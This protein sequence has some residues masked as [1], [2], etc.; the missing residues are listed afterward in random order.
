MCVKVFVSGA[1]SPA[2]HWHTAYPQ[3]KQASF[4][5]G[6]MILFDDEKLCS[7]TCE[8]CVLLDRWLPAAIVR[9]VEGLRGSRTAPGTHRWKPA[10]P[11][12]MQ[13][14]PLQIFSCLPPRSWPLSPC[15]ATSLVCDTGKTTQLRPVVG[16]ALRVAAPLGGGTQ[17]KLNVRGIP[18][19]LDLCGRLKCRR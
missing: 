19:K 3:N 16:A 7:R 17:T 14:R 9:L 1:G 2:H 18:W 6:A 13:R 10:S 12:R 15:S 5:L 8:L 4:F 11:C